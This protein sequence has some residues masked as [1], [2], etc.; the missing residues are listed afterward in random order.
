M[1]I[2]NFC[3]I[4]RK[5]LKQKITVPGVKLRVPIFYYIDPFLFKQEQLL[6]T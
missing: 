3:C 1:T 2:Y 5:I 4:G 6:S